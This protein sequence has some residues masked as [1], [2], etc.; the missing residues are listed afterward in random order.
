M[1]LTRKVQQ[2]YIKNI[3]N[4]KIYNQVNLR[5][6][7]SQIIKLEKFKETLTPLTISLNKSKIGDLHELFLTN[8]QINKLKYH[9]V[10]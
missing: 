4:N 9:I 7:Q 8:Q 5:L 3:N 1:I 10:T 2:K 6:T